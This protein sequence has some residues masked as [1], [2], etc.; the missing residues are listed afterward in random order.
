LKNLDKKEIK[1]LSFLQI[2]TPN[3]SKLV[4]DFTEEDKKIFPLSM[5]PHFY[6]NIESLYLIKSNEIVFGFIYYLSKIVMINER[7]YKEVGIYIFPEFRN[8][9]VGTYLLSNFRI[10]NEQFI[11]RISKSN[12]AM[13]KIVYNSS[14]IKILENTEDLL[15]CELGFKFT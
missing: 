1:E 10:N 4:K 7:H 15:V 5:N 12:L 2:D 6:R 11:L 13:C 3:Y 9:G 14:S 8:L